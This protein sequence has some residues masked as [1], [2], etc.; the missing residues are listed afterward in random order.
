MNYVIW[1]NPE[2]RDYDFG[3]QED[4]QLVCQEYDLIL[5][6]NSGAMKLS[7]ITSLTNRLN[8]TICDLKS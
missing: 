8:K 1:Y 3:T 2:V 6:Q 7:F 5:A 4:F